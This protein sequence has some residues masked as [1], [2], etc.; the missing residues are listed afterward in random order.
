MNEK[1]TIKKCQKGNK[2]AFNELIAFYYPFVFK[3]LRKLTMNKD[4]AEDLVQDVF[5]KLIHHIDSFD[6]KGKATFKTYL[7]TIAK[8]TYLDELRRKNK[9]F[10]E[11]DIN[12]IPDKTNFEEKYFQT[13]DYHF[14]LEK[15]EKLPLVQREAIKLKYL[16]GYTLKE[17]ADV[18]KVESKTIKS[19]LFEGRK[20]LKEELKGSDINE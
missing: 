1:K 14:I 8:N 16:E 18:Q 4:V 5:I 6:I 7:I 17:I 13:E 10:Q 19:R 15:I 20:K 9:E 3:F 2:E 12:T 11:I